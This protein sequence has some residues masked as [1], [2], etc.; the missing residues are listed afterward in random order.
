MTNDLGVPG[1]YWRDIVHEPRPELITGVPVFLGR[2]AGDRP[3]NTPVLLSSGPQF[4]TIFVPTS[5]DRQ[6]DVGPYLRYAVRGFFE[7][8][9]LLCYVIPLAV[10]A[11]TLEASSE[12]ALRAGLAAAAALEAVDLVC[13]PDLVDLS[14]TSANGQRDIDPKLQ[15]RVLDHCQVTGDRFAILDGG[16]NNSVDD[17]RTRRNALQADYGA[18]YFPW[19]S[20]M[21]EDGSNLAVP[22]CGHIAGIYAR[23]DQRVGVHKAPANEIV[24]GVLDTVVAGVPTPADDALLFGTGAN[25][26]RPF[27]G[28]GIRVWGA[29]TLSADPAWQYVHIRRL[30]LTVGRWLERFMARLVFEPNDVRLWARIMRELSAYF[31]ELFRQ[32]ALKGMRP[33]QAYYVK[34]DTETNPPERIE[35]GELVTEI[36]LSPAVPSEFIVARIIHGPSGLSITAGAA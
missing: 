21:R 10:G 35:R 16:P 29:R 18:L 9:G 4:E 14:A 22:P 7:N 5:N 31:D 30:F 23:S 2:A 19:V 11:N 34:C 15:R 12:G 20:V 6:N 33:E 1:V 13:A 25:Y 3:P 26:I 27:G 24:E 28:R 32:G 36:G 17:I 8:G